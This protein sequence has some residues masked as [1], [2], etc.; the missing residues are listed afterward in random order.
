MS[1]KNSNRINLLA[2]IGALLFLP[3]SVSAEVVYPVPSYDNEALTA[4]RE[5]EKTWAGKK[6]DKTNIDQVAEYLPES[7]VSVYKDP[8]KWGAPADNS[9]FHDKGL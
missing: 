4:V 3:M 1:R 5:W 6:I 8:E 2:L 7:F 9:Y